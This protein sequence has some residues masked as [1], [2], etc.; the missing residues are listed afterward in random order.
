MNCKR[1]L[2]LML[3]TATATIPLGWS[4]NGHACRLSTSKL[5]YGKEIV[6]SVHIELDGRSPALEFCWS[7]SVVGALG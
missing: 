1:R 7:T 3:Q 6:V 5:C 4:S 2:K